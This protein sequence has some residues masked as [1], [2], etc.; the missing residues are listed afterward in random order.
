MKHK[1]INSDPLLKDILL[2]MLD[3]DPFERISA[4][5]ATSHSYFKSFEENTFIKK[6]SIFLKSL[7]N[8]KE[9]INNSIQKQNGNEKNRKNDKPDRGTVVKQSL[10]YQNQ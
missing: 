4:S 5:R 10:F 7:Q 6:N 2:K 9:N 8:F 1:K 3:K